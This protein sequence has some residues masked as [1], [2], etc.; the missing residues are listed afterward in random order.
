VVL[1]VQVQLLLL[2]DHLLHM[3]VVGEELDIL[4]LEVV[5]LAAV[6]LVVKEIMEPIQPLEQL[7][8]AAVA[9]EA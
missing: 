9:V 7:I 5:D 6:A 2:Q 1:V 8:Q 4:E 3:L